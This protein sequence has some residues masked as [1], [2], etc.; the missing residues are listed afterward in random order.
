MTIEHATWGSPELLDQNRRRLLL[1]LEQELRVYE[2][3]YELSSHLVEQ[4][5][6]AGRLR[7]TAEICDWVIAYTAFR[8]L[9]D[10]R[11]A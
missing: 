5:L 2:R 3:R 8:A 4:E 7:E 10:G 9:Q 11:P 1:E 6:K